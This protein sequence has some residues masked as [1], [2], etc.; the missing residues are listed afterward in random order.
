MAGGGGSCLGMGRSSGGTL[1]LGRAAEGV[2]RRR[3]HPW[4]CGEE[5]ARASGKQGR[6]ASYGPHS[7]SSRQ[8]HRHRGLSSRTD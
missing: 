4:F 2:S 3:V 8:R 6:L 5:G 1:F 7:S